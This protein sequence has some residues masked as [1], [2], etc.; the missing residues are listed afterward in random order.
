MT[1]PYAHNGYFVTL[2]DVVHFYNTRDVENWPEPEVAANVNITELG[3][4][5]LTPQEEADLV[6]FLKT[7]TD[8]YGDKMPDN[9]VLPPITPLN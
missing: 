1:P 4:L 9:F 7:L 5:G 3:K 6:D 8:G 2:D